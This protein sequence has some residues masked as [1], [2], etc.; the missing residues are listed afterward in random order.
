[1]RAIE[2]QLQAGLKSPA[3]SPVVRLSFVVGVT[4][5]VLNTERVVSLK[6]HEYGRLGRAD[7]ELVLE[8][9]DGAVGWLLD[10]VNK[11]FFLEFGVTAGAE[12][13]TAPLYMW[14]VTGV[15]SIG[16]GQADRLQ[17]SAMNGYRLFN[18]PVLAGAT[19]TNRS[20]WTL[21]H[22]LCDRAGVPVSPEYASFWDHAVRLFTLAADFSLAFYLGQL[23][24]DGDQSYMRAYGRFDTS[25]LSLSLR[26]LNLADEPI[27]LIEAG[28]VRTVTVLR[29]AVPS[30]VTVYGAGGLAAAVKSG[31]LEEIEV[32]RFELFQREALTLH[33][34]T[35]AG[36]LV[37][38]AEMELM[39]NAESGETYLLECAPDLRWELWDVINVAG[40]SAMTPDA[41]EPT[42]LRVAEIWLNYGPGGLTY[43]LLGR[44]TYTDLGFITLPASV[45]GLPLALAGGVDQRSRVYTDGLTSDGDTLTIDPPDAAPPLTL[46]EHAQG[47]RVT[48]LDADLLDGRHADEFAAAD[49][50]HPDT[51]GFTAYTHVQAAPAS[52][53]TV[54]HNLGRKP[55]VTVIDSANSEV[56]G[57]VTHVSE[58][59]LEIAFSGAFSGVA[60]VV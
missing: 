35:Q 11:F 20:I 53:W 18:Q 58:S 21:I 52:Q 30:T 46:G 24:G 14:I 4:P 60:Y 32:G 43:K 34:F 56:L 39:D 40:L 13:N 47:Q 50:D 59:A 19:F 57:N 25:T 51:I 41:E 23:I 49:H 42:A 45:R 31:V 5:V 54:T 36:V 28:E 44:R 27:G 9:S 16:P 3:C 26:R 15:K 22:E 6:L 1:M 17:V 10:W 38:R 37:E 33:Q 29:K 7:L 12:V 8:N 48:G 2:A 55:S